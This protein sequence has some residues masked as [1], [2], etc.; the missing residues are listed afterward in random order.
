MAENVLNSQFEFVLIFKNENKPKRSINIANF[1]GTV[2]NVL[3][4]NPQRNNEFAN[5]HAATFSIDFAKYF[6]ETFTNE[7][8]D[9]IDLFG[10]TG[11]T[12]I[13]CEQTKR[14][15]FMME[16]D[17]KYCDVVVKRWEDYTGLKAERIE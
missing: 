6:I 15:C 1:R 7:T 12:L 16:L 8:N 11:T 2:S 4:M 10:G 3:N 9:I 14:N 5:I 17:E 13:A